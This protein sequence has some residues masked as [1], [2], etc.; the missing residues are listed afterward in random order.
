VRKAWNYPWSSAGYHVGERESDPLVRDRDLGG[1]VGNWREY[2]AGEDAKGEEGLR[3][4]TRSGRPWG[5]EKYVAKV[6]RLTGRDLSRGK[7]GRP[8]KRR[9]RDCSIFT[10]SS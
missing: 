5:D 6:E 9:N 7:P 8:R 3:K 2:L 1:R 4:A 10:E